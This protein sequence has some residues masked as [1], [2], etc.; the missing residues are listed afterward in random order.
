MENRENRRENSRG[1]SKRSSFRR[2][3]R[4]IT[5]DDCQCKY[6]GTGVVFY[7]KGEVL[8]RCKFCAMKVY[9][10]VA[11]EEKKRWIAGEHPQG[12]SY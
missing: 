10:Q 12:V 6:H 11:E 9:E 4:Y 1:R 2:N 3:W 7:S 5:V 8:F